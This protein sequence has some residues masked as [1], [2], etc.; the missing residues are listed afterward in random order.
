MFTSDCADERILK[1]VNIW[2]SYGVMRLGDLLFCGPPGISGCDYMFLLTAVFNANTEELSKT[3]SKWAHRGHSIWKDGQVLWVKLCGP[4]HLLSVPTIWWKCWK[5]SIV[6]V[7]IRSVYC[8][9]SPCFKL[10]CYVRWFLV[11]SEHIYSQ[12]CV[13][14][15]F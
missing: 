8:K 14:H 13:S 6:F 9:P 7:R 2:Q 5:N 11:L 12:K 1:I 3:F 10:L 15:T 4:H